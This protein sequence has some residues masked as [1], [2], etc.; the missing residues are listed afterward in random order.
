MPALMIM[1][2]A[3]SDWSIGGKTDHERPLAP[4]GV[5]AAGIMGRF[6]ARCGQ[7]PELALTSTAVRAKSTVELAAEAGSWKCEIRPV[8]AFY[9]CDPETVFGQLAAA[10]GLPERVLI[11]GHEPAWSDLV[12]ELCGGRVRMPTAA[13]ASVEVGGR[14]WQEIA[15]G[16][17]VLRWLVTPKLAKELL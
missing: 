4:R 10:N 16:R 13:V 9:G 3:K 17:G 2:H 6:L 5:T 15:P 14:T 11:V 1:R 8:G 7:S 12:A